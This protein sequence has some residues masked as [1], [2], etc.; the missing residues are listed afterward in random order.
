MKPVIKK[1]SHY[2][3]LLMKDDS[4]ARTFRVHGVALKILLAIFLVFLIAG[5]AGIAGGIYFFEEYLRL[6]SQNEMQEKELSEMRLQLERLVNLE[7]LIVASNSTPPLAK[8]EEVGATAPPP[9]VIADGA[10]PAADMQSAE[11]PEQAPDALAAPAEQAK[12]QQDEVALPPSPSTEDPTYLSLNAADSPLRINGFQVR[13]TGRERLR[14]SYELATTPSDEPRTVSGNIRYKALLSNGSGVDLIS[15]DIEGKR[16]AI[17]R[18][19]PIQSSVR[20]PQGH[21]AE[22][23]NN[24]AVFIELSDGTVYQDI[25]AL[26]E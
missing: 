26:A 22:N 18:M 19:K 21:L 1:Q 24:I 7:S 6:T 15:Y 9:K 4:P 25:F 8:N 10:L 23:I 12:E 13:V 20:L 16:F 3:L 5:G 11:H 14:I 17:A 2:N